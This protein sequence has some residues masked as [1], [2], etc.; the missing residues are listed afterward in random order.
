MNKRRRRSSVL[1][2]Q[3]PAWRGTR[4]RA[5]GGAGS[6]A[7]HLLFH[8]FLILRPFKVAGLDITPPHLAMR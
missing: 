6:L 4:G 1:L 5:V 8:L 2:S 3:V 7:L